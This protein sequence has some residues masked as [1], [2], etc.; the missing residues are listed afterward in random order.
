MNSWRFGMWTTDEEKTIV[1]DDAKSLKA[2]KD[3]GSSI[4][5]GAIRLSLGGIYKNKIDGQE[6]Q[7]IEFVNPH[8]SLFKNLTTLKNQ[9]LSIHIFNNVNTDD[10]SIVCMD[11]DEISHEDWRKAQE[12]LT[13][14]QPLL[15]QDENYFSGQGLDKRAKECGVSVRTLQR[16][17]S[18]YLKTNSIASLIEKKRGWREGN[19]R[20]TQVQLSIINEVIQDYYLTIQR[21]TIQATIQEVFKRCYQSNIDKPSKNAI[22]Y[23]IARID[24]KDYLKARGYRERAKNKFTPKVGSFPTVERPLAVIQIDHTP[25][26][27]ILV[28][29][30]HR[31]PIGRPYITV[32][33]DIYSRMITG[34]YISL[35]APSV[36]SVAMCVTRSILPKQELLLQYGI[37]DVH[38]DVFGIPEKIHVDNGSDFRSNS[39]SQ[40]CALHGIMLEFRPLARPE[41]GGHIER[42]IGNLMENVHKLPGTTFSNIQKKDGYDSEKHASLTLEEFERWF[43]TYITKVYH[44]KPHSALGCSPARQW[45]IGLFGDS[46][47]QGMGIPAIPSDAQTLILDFM[48]SFKRSIQHTGVSIDGLNYYDPCLNHYMNVTDHKTGKKKNFI[49]RQDPRDISVI[50]FYD[51]KLKQYFKVPC[52]NQAFPPM[53]Q[54]QY[55][56]IKKQVKERS[57]TINESLIYEAWDEMQALVEDAT[58]NTKTLR[59]QEQRRK[60]HIKSQQYHQ[61]SLVN[62]SI[63]DDNSTSNTSTALETGAEDYLDNFSNNFPQRQIMKPTPALPVS[64]DTSYPSNNGTDDDLDYFEDIE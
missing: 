39:L 51:P 26:D 1:A 24:E 22:R 20:I 30:K 56:I 52:A 32:A 12:K 43:L 10:H 27:I 2:M 15:M 33:I 49:F 3:A 4:Q 18:A 63:A 8:E 61:Q 40:S 11:V 60:N 57:G 62:D 16:W 7:L 35:D 28:D 44:Q 64:S 25:A 54:W 47:S 50:W 17:M 23:Q 53:S 55:N 38:W 19:R 21:P 42:L 46:I 37:T 36:T 59:R 45:E 9:L 29:D 13:A 41:Y 58:K 5:R 14:I 6:Y 34:Y 31:K 48:P